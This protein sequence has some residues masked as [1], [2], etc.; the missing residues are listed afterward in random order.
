MPHEKI[1][2]IQRAGQRYLLTIP[3]DVTAALSRVEYLTVEFDGEHLVYS[4]V[5]TGKEAV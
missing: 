3:R 2:K 4:P 5:R 1:V